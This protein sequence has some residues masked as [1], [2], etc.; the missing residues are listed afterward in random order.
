MASFSCMKYIYKEV[1][2]SHMKLE[3]IC[4]SNQ[5]T[6]DPC[7]GIYLILL[8]ET[9]FP[10]RLIIFVGLSLPHVLIKYTV[11][12]S[13]LNILENCA[14]WMKTQNNLKNCVPVN[15][16]WNSLSLFYFCHCITVL[17]N[18]TLMRV[19]RVKRELLS[20]CIF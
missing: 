4:C 6:T 17:F 1:H 13:C 3:L 19:M 5:P 2:R 7:I 15:C 12:F 11:L 18:D 10:Y 14:S 8:I 9:S 20:V 16:N